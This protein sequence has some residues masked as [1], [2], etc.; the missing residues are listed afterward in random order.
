MI[1]CVAN[2][3]YWL[4]RYLERVDT[5]S[6]LLAVTSSYSLDVDFDGSALWRP[7]VI[8]GG[9]EPHFIEQ[10][11]E[12]QIEDSEIV[13]RY[14]VWDAE[15]PLSIYSSFR[16]VRENARTIREVMTAARRLARMPAARI[17]ASTCA[18]PAAS[19]RANSAWS[20]AM[21]VMRPAL[22]RASAAPGTA[23]RISSA[24]RRKRPALAA[25]VAASC[26][27]STRS[28]KNWKAPIM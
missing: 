2:S 19:R 4:T 10:I 3:C 13:Q 15:N 5:W 27:Y 9:H 20:T 21:S 28:G 24:T 25:R 7:L 26:A 11:G 16:A 12:D 22:S 18:I 17:R 14:L 8:V 6:R 23:A 1:S